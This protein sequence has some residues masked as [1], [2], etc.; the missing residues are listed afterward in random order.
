MGSRI[1]KQQLAIA[2][3][4]QNPNVADAAKQAGIGHRTLTRWLSGDPEFQSAYRDA[5]KQVVQGAIDRIR[6]ACSEAVTALREIMT[7]AESPSSSRVS[8]A[9]T[10]LEMAMRSL[11]V[12]EFNSRLAEL[13]RQLT[14]LTEG[15]SQR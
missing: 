2:A 3:L 7:D 13:E 12:E 9:R 8:A 15:G 1:S 5:K 4:L 10:I 11:E 14:T 6:A